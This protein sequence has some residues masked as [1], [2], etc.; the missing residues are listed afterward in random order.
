MGK[1]KTT[2]PS[3]TDI[4]KTTQT[5]YQG[6][7]TP[8]QS[9]N[10]MGEVGNKMMGHYDTAVQRNMQ[11]YGDIMG[12][13]KNFMGGLK[14]S[15]ERVNYQRPGELGEAYGALRG[16]LPGYQEFAQTGGYSDKDVQEL[17]AR[18]IAPIRSAYG[19]TMMEL[20]R[21]RAL[22]GGGGAT[23]Y[24]A[25]RS[26]A[27]REL[28][29]QMADAMTG[30]NAN[31]AQQIREGRL[32]GLGGMTQVGG[33]MGG[34]ASDEAG[35][36]LQAQGMNQAAGLQAQGQ[37]NQ[38]MLGALGGQQGLYG[39]TPGLSN[40]FGNQALNAYGQRGELEQGRRS[41][42]LGLLDAQTRLAGM[43]EQ[44][45]PW[46]KTALSI[47][48]TAAPYVAMA[49]S[50]REIKHDIKKVGSGKS[51]KLAKHLKD[52]PLYTWKYNG[53]DTTHFGPIAEEFKEKF[54]VGDGKTLHLADVMGVVLAAGKE[55]VKDA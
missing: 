31:L 10:Q 29:G 49:A 24:I 47:A 25:A 1:K 5:A 14:P 2:T 50:S 23:N 26:R 3:T 19:N 34:L 20:D 15:F 4:Y 32:A 51:S 53:E 40:M 44:K 17:R 54:G 9:E 35:R 8:S 28:P 7:Q 12:G 36:M 52:L 27:Q 30:V 33:T 48:G 39:T 6:S 43:Q 11:D 16:A 55:M 13:Y 21:A 45:T 46:W 38:A 18:G 37:Y 41:Y 22:G 42:G